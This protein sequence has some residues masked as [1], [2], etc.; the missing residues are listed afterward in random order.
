M[1]S[2]ARWASAATA[3]LDATVSHMVTGWKSV[4][5]KPVDKFFQKDGAG[6]LVPITIKGTREAPDFGVDFGRIGFK[7]TKPESPADKQP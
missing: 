3:R 6:T 4:L 7:G 1:R 2:M 5:L